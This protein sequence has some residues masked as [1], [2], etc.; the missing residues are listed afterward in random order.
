MVTILGK[1]YNPWADWSSDIAVL[2][3]AL[4]EYNASHPGEEKDFTFPEPPAP[5]WWS[6]F[7]HM[8]GEYSMAKD[9]FMKEAL[10]YDYN[11]FGWWWVED[12]RGTNQRLR[13]A[14]DQYNAE[15]PNDPLPFE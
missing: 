10:G 15:H 14:Y 13:D 8:L 4:N 6:N 9:Q 11:Y 2:L 1:L 12:E 7:E 5:V 3:E